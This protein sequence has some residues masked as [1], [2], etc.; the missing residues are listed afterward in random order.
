MKLCMPILAALAAMVLLTASLQA[1]NKV[2]VRAEATKEWVDARADAS[3]KAQTYQLMKG[4]YFPGDL[5]RITMEEFTFAE[6]AKDLA[7]NL[8]KQNFL[9]DP[10]YGE[11]DLVLVVH[12]GVTH[13]TGLASE[14]RD[15]DTLQDLGYLSV[16]DERFREDPIGWYKHISPRSIHFKAR[17]LGMEEVFDWR[18][19]FDLW[20]LRIMIDQPRFFVI[21]MAYDLPLAKQGTLK[22]HWMTRY[23]IRAA[24]QSY[25]QAVP[26]LNEVAGDFFGKNFESLERQFPMSQPTVEVGEIEVL[27]LDPEILDFSFFQQ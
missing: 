13:V 19:R 15:Y 8:Q 25:H 16:P 23:S 2:I 26:Y 22:L 1:K 24:G 9:P 17:L 12:Y 27:E 3:S 20:D 5:K 14:A 11:G 10:R 21:L 7:G 4:R 18:K 6:L